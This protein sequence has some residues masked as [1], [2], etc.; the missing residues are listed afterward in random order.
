M[1][2]VHY[3]WKGEPLLK[4]SVTYPRTDRSSKR[5]YLR[6]LKSCREFLI[7]KKRGRLWST[8]NLFHIWCA[9]LFVVAFIDSFRREENS[10]AHGFTR[11]SPSAVSSHHPRNPQ[12]APDDHG[13]PPTPVCYKGNTSHRA[14]RILGPCSKFLPGTKSFV[15]GKFAIPILISSHR[16]F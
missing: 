15:R 11:C 9:C 4:T 14:P 8:G 6:I 10:Q 3:C 7:K 12:V 13:N 1:R 2:K 16:L 5:S